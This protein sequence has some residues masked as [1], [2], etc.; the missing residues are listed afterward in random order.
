MIA[1]NVAAAETLSGLI[2]PRGLSHPR[3]ARSR[4]VRRC[5]CAKRSPHARLLSL[6]KGAT[7]QA[8]RISTACWD[9]GAGQDLNEHMVNTLVLRTQAQAVYSP[10]NIGHFRTGFAQVRPFHLADPALLR[11]AGAPGTDRRHASWAE[12]GWSLQRRQD[13]RTSSP[14]TEHISMTERRASAM[15]ERPEPVD[16]LHGRP[17]WP[18][19]S[20]QSSRDA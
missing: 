17:I 6:P 15:A 10:E 5:A 20:A 7:A 14:I 4:A 2:L 9:V 13:L 12:G 3:D 8:R 18:T 19:A 16:R 11:S 1:A